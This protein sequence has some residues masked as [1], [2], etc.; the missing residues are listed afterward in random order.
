MHGKFFWF[1]LMAADPA[2]A[3]DFYRQV[4]GWGVQASGAAGQDYTLFTV[5]DQGVAGLMPIPDEMKGSG[6]TAWMTY[7]AVDD[8]DR[9]VARL[10]ELGGVLHKGPIEVPGIIRFAVVSDPQGAGFLIAKGLS[11]EPMREIR[12]GT[13]GV[14][15]WHELYADDP[16]AALAFYEAMFGWTRT[17]EFDLGPM[18]LYRTFATGAQPVGGVMPWRR[19]GRRPRPGGRGRG[20]S[21]R[22]P[23][24]G[25]DPW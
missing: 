24:P 13:P 15:G 21:T 4:V 18:G 12:P 16:D 19:P 22:R 11:T 3:A 1:D 5:D 7:V 9:A 8:V 2:V 25:A 14:A 20:R 10:R 23:G 6:Q 17:E